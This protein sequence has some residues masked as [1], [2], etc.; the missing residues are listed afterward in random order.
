MK[1]TRENA[2]IPLRAL[3]LVDHMVT[4]AEIISIDTAVPGRDP[5]GST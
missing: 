5:S 3:S 4:A 2:C 1:S